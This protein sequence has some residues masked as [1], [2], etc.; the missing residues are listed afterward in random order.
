MLDL[1]SLHMHDRSIASKFENRTQAN[2]VTLGSCEQTLGEICVR[3]QQT[4]LQNTA[5]PEIASQLETPALQSYCSIEHPS[6]HTQPPEHTSTYVKPPTSTSLCENTFTIRTHV[7][8]YINTLNFKSVK[9]TREPIRQF[10]TKKKRP[11]ALDKNSNNIIY[12]CHAQKES[13]RQ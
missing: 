9:H 1:V 2:R 10:Q 8:K 4:E 12:C 13:F 11:K 3:V 6:L 5:V 7:S